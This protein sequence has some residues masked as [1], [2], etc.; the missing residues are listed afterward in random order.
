M[1]AAK[2]LN[3][4]KKHL[5]KMKLFANDAIKEMKTFEA[6]LKKKR[7]PVKRKDAEI[8]AIVKA[9]RYKNESV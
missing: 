2:K 6:S 3:I 7:K 9:N 1:S 5:L 4:E 8:V